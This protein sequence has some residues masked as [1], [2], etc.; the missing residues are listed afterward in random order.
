LSSRLKRA[1]DATA[2]AGFPAEFGTK[3]RLFCAVMRP[4]NAA[5][6]V[7]ALPAGMS[8]LVKVRKAEMAR[9]RKAVKN[10]LAGVTRSYRGVALRPAD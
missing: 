8:R 5:P 6:G 1:D 3:R 4:S 2:F 7:L 9:F 10:S